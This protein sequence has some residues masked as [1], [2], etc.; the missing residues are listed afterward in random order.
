MGSGSNSCYFIRSDA[1]LGL[2]YALGQS[3]L[4]GILL[5]HRNEVILQ[6]KE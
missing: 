2:G 4:S 6:I 3:E 1:L 5:Y